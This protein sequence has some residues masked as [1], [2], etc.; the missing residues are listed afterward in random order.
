METLI[1]SKPGNTINAMAVIRGL[2][3]INMLNFCVSV[4][5]VF[6][7]FYTSQ[8]SNKVI[9]HKTLITTYI[10]DFLE[11]GIFNKK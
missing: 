6:L 11:S 8:Q 1:Y 4:D 2:T 3:H 5:Y 9:P 7:S 10:M